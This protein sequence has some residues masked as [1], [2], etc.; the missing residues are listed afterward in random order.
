MSLAGVQTVLH[1]AQKDVSGLEIEHNIELER[2]TNAK[3][4]KWKVGEQRDR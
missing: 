4:L 1:Q 2:R 3:K